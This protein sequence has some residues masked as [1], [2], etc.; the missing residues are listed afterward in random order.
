MHQ[1]IVTHDPSPHLRHAH[2]PHHSLTGILTLTPSPPPP[3]LSHMLPQPPRCSYRY[4]ALIGNLQIW[5]TQ[6]WSH[7]VWRD[8]TTPTP[9][10]PC[11]PHANKQAKNVVCGQ[12]L[13][14]VRDYEHTL[15]LPS[16]TYIL[17]GFASVEFWENVMFAFFVSYL[18]AH[19]NPNSMQPLFVVVPLP[20]AVLLCV[21]CI[22]VCDACGVRLLL[23]WVSR[24]EAGVWVHHVCE[25]GVGWKC[26]CWRFPKPKHQTQNLLLFVGG[27]GV[28][29]PSRLW[30]VGGSWGM[31]GGDPGKPREYRCPLNHTPPG[32]CQEACRPDAWKKRISRIQ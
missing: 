30:G 26:C 1:I 13:S 32:Q 27:W 8:T 5:V 16:F 12:V 22:T 18:P 31:M 25:D 11:P 29:V 23:R 20:T 3:P 6:W 10:P 14:Y 19:T 2:T 4:A 21:N 7:L 24:C 15:V 9:R 28:Y 17:L